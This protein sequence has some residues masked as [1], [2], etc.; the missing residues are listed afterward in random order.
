MKATIRVRYP[1][2]H[3]RGATSAGRR[4]SPYGA[5]G[6]MPEPDALLLADLLRRGGA[7]VLIEVTP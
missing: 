4:W 1:P 7:E 6:S 3:P 2:Q 5:G